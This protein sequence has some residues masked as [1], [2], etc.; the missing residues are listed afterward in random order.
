MEIPGTNT[1]KPSMFPLLLYSTDR[2]QLS[3]RGCALF[4]PQMKNMRESERERER[5]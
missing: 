5:E 4:I 1:E 3:V 2:S